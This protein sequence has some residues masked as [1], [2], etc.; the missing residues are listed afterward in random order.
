MNVGFVYEVV[1]TSERKKRWNNRNSNNNDNDNSGRVFFFI[2][3][4]IQRNKSEVL[5]A[6]FL[7]SERMEKEKIKK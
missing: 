1:D 3:F 6:S 4:S 7:L 5:S 2:H